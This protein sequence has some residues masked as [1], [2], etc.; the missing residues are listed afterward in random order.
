MSA[1][2]PL[3][4][5]SP[6][7]HTWI[8]AAMTRDDVAAARSGSHRRPRRRSAPARPRPADAP[9]ALRRRFE[10][11]A[12]VPAPRSVRHAC[13][14]HAFDIRFREAWDAYVAVNEAFADGGRRGRARRRRSCSCRTTS[15]RSSPRSCARR[16]PDLRIVHFTHT[17]FCGPD[18]IRLLPTDVAELLCRSLGERPGRV[19]H[20]PLGRVVR[21]HDARGARRRRRRCSRSRLA[22]GPD[23]DALDGDRGRTATRAKRPTRSPTSSA[24]AS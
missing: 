21:R 12:V 9:A 6:T 20:E 18:G 3:L 8:A 24:T 13:A 10:R 7:E 2:G 23:V 22:L 5:D 4:L 17:P 15:S 11:R 16:R 19:P 14:D 1:L